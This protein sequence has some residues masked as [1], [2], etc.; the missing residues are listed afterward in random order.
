[1]DSVGESAVSSLVTRAECI[2]DGSI[3]QAFDHFDRPRM[4][5]LRTDD[6]RIA[7][8]AI[9]T[10]T[11]S[12]PDRFETVRRRA[13]AARGTDTTG[14]AGA[15]PRWYGGG[16]FAPSATDEWPAFAATQFV[17]PAVVA[18]RIDGDTWL[19]V[20]GRDRSRVDTRFDRLRATIAGQEPPRHEPPGV[21]SVRRRPDRPEW[22]RQ[23][24]HATEAI[25]AGRLQK[26]VLARSLVADLDRAIDAGSALADLDGSYP[27]CTRFAIAPAGGGTFLGATPETLLDHRGRTVRTTALAGSAARGPSAAADADRAAELQASE[28]DDREHGIVV[29]A[30]RE[31]LDALPASVRVGSRRLRRLASVQ[32]LETPIEARLDDD[33]HALTVVDALHPTPAVGGQ[34]IDRALDWIADR[35]RIDRGWYAAPVGWFDARGD[36]SFAVA[37]RSALVREDRARCF[38]GAGIV[39]DSDPDAE[40]SETELKYR[41]MLDL[42]R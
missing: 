24:E 42:F 16:A 41:P 28:K 11:A 27:D 5:W 20:R 29:E 4:A 10:V 19:V 15:P 1:M 35:E 37:I 40:W 26:V 33:T 23:V 2:A 18:A 8:G 3:L 17:L 7:G 31:Q 39:A 6:R 25:D 38:A 34:P 22:T 13:T 9:A 30:I 12:G 14:P 36:G 32:H 21:A